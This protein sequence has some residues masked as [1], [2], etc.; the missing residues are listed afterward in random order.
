MRHLRSAEHE[1]RV[2]TTDFRLADP[3]DEE[4]RDVH[5]QL[6]WYWRDHAFPAFSF[7][8]RLAVERHNADVLDRHVREFAPDV[9]TWW[10]MGGM[11]LSLLERVRRAGIPAVAFV[12]DD[13][14]DYGMRADRWLAQFRGRARRLAAAPAQ[15][16]FRTPTRVRW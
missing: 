4:D 2:L 7:R 13:W 12:H 9:V 5:R 16:I 14:M 8:E 1:V 6:H 15:A 11:S 10:A 3:D